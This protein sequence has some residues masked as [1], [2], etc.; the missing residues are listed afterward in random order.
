VRTAHHLGVQDYANFS[1][2]E[3]II[4]RPVA[5]KIRR[6]RHALQANC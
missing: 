1:I 6:T 5:A 3:E 4:G 2:N